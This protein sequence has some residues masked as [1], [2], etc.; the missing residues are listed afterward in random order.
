MERGRTGEVFAEFLE[1]VHERFY[2][3]RRDI[4]RYMGRFQVSH[5]GWGRGLWG[6]GTYRARR[7][8]GIG[9]RSAVSGFADG[10]GDEGDAG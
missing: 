2:L 8:N 7:A 10:C 5:A 9:D 1:V 3:V 6:R 4:G